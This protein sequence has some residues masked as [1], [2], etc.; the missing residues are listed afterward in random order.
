MPP[1]IITRKLVSTC[2]GSDNNSLLATLLEIEDN[3][4]I[5]IP[6]GDDDGFAVPT[7]LDVLNTIAGVCMPVEHRVMSDHLKAE[8]QWKAACAFLGIEHGYPYDDMSGVRFLPTVAATMPPD[9][10]DLLKA[11]DRKRKGDYRTPGRVSPWNDLV[12]LTEPACAT[13]SNGSA[14]AA[15]GTSR[16]LRK[17]G[18]VWSSLAGSPSVAFWVP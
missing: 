8:A 7:C 17:A 10:G 3:P 13:R 12:N 18:P 11:D 5:E 2:I 9:Y 1:L 4:T 6:I 15:S 14:A 16:T